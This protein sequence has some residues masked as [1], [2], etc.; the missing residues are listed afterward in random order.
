MSRLDTTNV[1]NQMHGG[2]REYDRVGAS[3]ML[4]RNVRIHR[5]GTRLDNSEDLLSRKTW[6][7]VSVTRVCVECT[8]VYYCVSS[9][10]K[11]LIIRTSYGVVAVKVENV[12][13]L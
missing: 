11:F 10:F 8:A 5:K 4:L 1:A 9:V 2:S 6:L 7:F 3:R 12:C 13:I